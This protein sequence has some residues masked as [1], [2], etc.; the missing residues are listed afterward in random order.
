DDKYVVLVDVEG[1]FR[2]WQL[3]SRAVLKVPGAFSEGAYGLAAFSKDSRLLAFPNAR[4]GITI[5]DIVA[6]KDRR[7]LPNVSN[8]ADK[9]LALAFTPDGSLACATSHGRIQLWDIKSGRKQ[10][11]WRTRPG[12]HG[13]FSSDA[14]LLAIQEGNGIFRVVDIAERKA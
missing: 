5:F 9:V 7:L 2:F 13:T 11:S 3:P 14:K 8:T 6:E 12:D 1:T 10:T 4:G